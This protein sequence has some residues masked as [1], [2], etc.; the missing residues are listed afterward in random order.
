MSKKVSTGPQIAPPHHVTGKA[1]RKQAV[2]KWR[3]KDKAALRSQ[4]P[5][6]VKVS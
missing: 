6:G 3:R 5:P 1:I 2:R 4:V